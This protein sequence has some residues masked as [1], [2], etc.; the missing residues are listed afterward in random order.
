[1]E[2]KKK[3]YYYVLIVIM[4]ALMMFIGTQSS[5]GFGLMVNGIA[6]KV[7]LSGSQSSLLFSIKNLSAFCFVFLADKYYQKLGLRI[8]VS[9]AFVYGI[10]A[11][12]L[13]A[14]AGNNYALYCVAAAVLGATYAFTMILPMALLIRTWFNK[15]RALGMSICSAG[16]GL[17]TFVLS[18]RLQSIINT[19]G[20]SS[21]FI[22]L[23]VVF[24]VGGIVFFLI[25]RNDPS[26]VGLE[27]YGG[28]NYVDEKKGNK[29]S[30]VAIVKTNKQA[31]LFFTICA[32]LMGFVAAPAQSHF[33]L[34]F[35]NL[36][37][38]SMFVATAY[39][40]LGLTL[41]IAKPSVGVLSTK[42]PF[43]VLSVIFVSFYAIAF[44]AACLA[45]G[46]GVAGF[47]PY[48]VFI[49]YG[50]G[51]PLTSLGYTNWIADFSTKEEYPKKVKNAQ[52]AYQGAEIIGAMT[53]GIVLD[54][55]GQYSLWYG[56]AACLVVVIII[57]VARTYLTRSKWLQSQAKQA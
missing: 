36:G 43:G 7:G 38:D 11:M 41:L 2:K 42:I 27:V 19:K 55:T 35:N 1:M 3:S 53:P 10:G 23:A 33:I 30:A 25:V 8:G 48:F 21:A 46:M 17:S 20:L 50:I 14:V 49:A 34:H 5:S 51:G 45:G 29:K 4:G 39:S 13:F 9:L 52:F 32:L 40:I 18:P 16:T 44:G 6:A 15:Y 22:F 47:M 28:E 37:Y 57:I 24:A 12:A 31:V 54:M 56:L 26:E